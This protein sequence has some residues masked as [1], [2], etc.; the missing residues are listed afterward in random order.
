MASYFKIN[1]VEPGKN[2]GPAPSKEKIQ[3]LFSKRLGISPLLLVAFIGCMVTGGIFYVMAF[4]LPMDKQ[5]EYS[6]SQLAKLTT[7]YNIKSNFRYEKKQKAKVALK[8]IEELKKKQEGNFYWAERMKVLKRTLVKDLWLSSLDIR[9]LRRAVVEDKKSAQGKSAHG[10]KGKQVSKQ[11]KGN[12]KEEEQNKK[13]EFQVTIRGATYTNPAK[14]PLKKISKFMT[15]LIDEP[16]WGNYFLLKD[17]N[18]STKEDVTN[19]EVILE[20]K[21]L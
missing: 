1:F 8:T 9:E 16:Y 21:E 15:N 7:E 3:R 4:Y 17:W 6:K 18:I 10:G 20:S 5:I 11:N 13:K 14:K 12:K 2:L 19:F